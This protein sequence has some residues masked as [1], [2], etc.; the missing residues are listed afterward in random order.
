MGILRCPTEL[1]V[2]CAMLIH[3]IDFDKAY[4]VKLLMTCL[5]LIIFAITL[6]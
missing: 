5:C 3:Y 4:L 2:K 1:N 6:Y